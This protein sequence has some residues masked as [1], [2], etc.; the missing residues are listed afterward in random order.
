MIHS[1]NKTSGEVNALS[2][3]VREYIARHCVTLASHMSA[4]PLSPELVEGSKDEQAQTNADNECQHPDQNVRTT[5]N[6][7]IP[8]RA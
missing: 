7:L 8:K 5:T 2:L 4:Q 1:K 6:R 3:I